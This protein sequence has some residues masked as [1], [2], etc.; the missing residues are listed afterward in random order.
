MMENHAQQE[1]IATACSPSMADI[2]DQSLHFVAEPPVKLR[3]C[4][5]MGLQ[6]SLPISQN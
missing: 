1:G 5:Y 2:T 4:L 6:A 3:I